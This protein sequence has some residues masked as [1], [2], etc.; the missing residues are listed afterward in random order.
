MTDHAVA[1]KIADFNEEEYKQFGTRIGDR[2]TFSLPYSDMQALEEL[3][4]NHVL[5]IETKLLE[6]AGEIIL[7]KLIPKQ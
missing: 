1:T 5:G 4:P 2:W 7:G 6:P 3:L